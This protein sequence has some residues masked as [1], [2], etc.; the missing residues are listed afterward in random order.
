MMTGKAGVGEKAEGAKRKL[1]RS[2]N[3]PFFS[4]DEAI[5]KVR[6]VFDHERRHPT[7]PD[8]ILNHLGYANQRSG[9]GGRALSA[10]RQY[11]LLEERD[12]TY[13]VSDLANRL[14]HVAEGSQEH[15]EAIREA[16]H[17]PLMFR[18]L[19]S[20]YQGEL[21]SDAT[22]RSYLIMDRDFNPTTVD[23]F[24]RTF[25]KTIEFAKPALD[26]YTSGDEGLGGDTMKGEAVERSGPGWMDDAFRPAK[27]PTPAPAA[28]GVHVYQWQ[29][30]FP[31]NVR[32][33]VRIIGTDFRR[34][35]IRILKKQVELLEET[36]TDTEHA[37]SA[38]PAQASRE[39]KKAESE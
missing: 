17:K 11:G 19:L 37:E 32:A 30:S 20:R 7:K 4:L 36:F 12:G 2:P 13:R 38:Q 14:L 26:G 27:A 21:P 29:L 31:R 15:K 9:S 6:L 3:Y 39:I 5:E 33:E 10:L 18:E 24:I 22:L 34:E 28:Q 8:V 16:A 25:R 1:L 23:H 35:D